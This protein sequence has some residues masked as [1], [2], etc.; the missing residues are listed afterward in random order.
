MRHREMRVL[1]ALQQERIETLERQLRKRWP[2]SLGAT[3][4]HR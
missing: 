1:I 4:R 3:P 2:A